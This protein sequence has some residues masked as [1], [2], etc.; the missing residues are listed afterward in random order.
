MLEY[1][2]EGGWI[3][4][5]LAFLSMLSLAIIID[6]W[7]AFV[8]TG[9]ETEEFRRKV[10]ASLSDG[11][12]TRAVGACQA[13]HSPLAAVTLAGLKKYRKMLLDG[14]TVVEMETVVSKTM[15]DYA[16]RALAVLEKRF[17]LL[18]LV[19]SVSPLLGITGTVVGMIMAFDNLSASGNTG[20]VASGISQ[21]LLTTAGGL[22]VAMPA[23]I[24]YNLFAKRA[25]DYMLVMEEMISDVISFTSD[26]SR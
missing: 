4:A 9:D 6:R 12:L 2:L 23:I 22:L 25:D 10:I 24:A 11:D 18:V 19:A 1:L 14:H 16:P 13:S 5:P 15:E 20:A 3:M 26:R 21:A 7:R 8:K 17:N